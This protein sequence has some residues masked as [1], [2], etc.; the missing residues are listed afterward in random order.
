M[1][2]APTQRVA[3]ITYSPHPNPYLA[4]KAQ[5]IGSVAGAVHVHTPLA[6]LIVESTTF[7]CSEL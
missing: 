5:N 7:G 6:Q 1:R 4:S 2:R 3:A